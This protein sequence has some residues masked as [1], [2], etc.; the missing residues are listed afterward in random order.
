[1]YEDIAPIPGR[2]P[3]D[4]AA[5]RRA[6]YWSLLNA[7][8]A[9]VAYG[10]H[11]LWGWHDQPAEAMNHPGMGVGQPWH[12]AMRLPGSDDMKR[13]ADC[14]TS[15]HWWTLRPD[16]DLIELQPFPKD[17]ARF[18]TAS[19]SDAGDLAVVYLPAGGQIT[20]RAGR[21]AHDLSATWFNP[22]TAERTTATPD[23]PNQFTVP[24]DNDW[25]LIA[26]QG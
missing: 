14:F 5:V 17:P 6:A 22:R 15:L 3:F 4:L 11:G 10:A 2:P 19:R 20:L 1:V 21:L 12:V 8:T 25:L 16:P 18:V 24:D 9:G 13:L 23:A 7:P 26:S